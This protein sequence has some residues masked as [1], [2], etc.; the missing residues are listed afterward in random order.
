MIRK[1]VNAILDLIEAVRSAVVKAVSRVKE[2][3]K[4][5]NG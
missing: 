2:S 3:L 1:L 4:R 5:T